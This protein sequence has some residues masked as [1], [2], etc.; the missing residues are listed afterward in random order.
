MTNPGIQEIPK[1]RADIFSCQEHNESPVKNNVVSIRASAEAMRLSEENEYK[2]KTIKPNAKLGSMDKSLH[3]RLSIARELFPRRPFPWD[4]LNDQLTLSLKQLG[5]AHGILPDP[6]PGTAM[7][8]LASAFGRKVIIR[9]KEDFTESLIFWFMDIKSMGGGKTGILEALAAPVKKLQLTSDERHEA[10]LEEWNRLSAE[11]QKTTE[12]PKRARGYWSSSFTMEG[13]RND[14]H[15]HPTGGYLFALDEMSS[16]FSGQ[17]AY[18][19]GRGSDREELC[20]LFNG[21]AGRILRAKEVFSIPPCAPSM[22]GGIQPGVFKR[23]LGGEKGLLLEDGTITRFLP[24]YNKTIHKD[25]T[26][27][28]VWS[29]ENQT[30]WDDLVKKA[31]LLAG[32]IDDSFIISFSQDAANVFWD[33]R[34]Q[35]NRI[36]KESIKIPLIDGFIQKAVT[37][38]VRFSGFLAILDS[39]CTEKPIPIQLFVSHINAGIKL[40]E[41]YLGQAVDIA[42]MFLENDE[43]IHQPDVVTDETLRLAKVL[44]FLRGETDKGLLAIGFITNEYNR[45]SSSKDQITSRKMGE[46]ISMAGLTKTP[47]LNDANGKRAVRCLVWDDKTDHYLKILSSTSERLQSPEVQEIIE[48]DAKKSMLEAAESHSGIEYDKDGRVILSRRGE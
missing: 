36:S 35:N 25:V 23:T 32:S 28:S 2:A 48:K 3:E 8:V 6:I 42:R 47:G 20:S 17:N 29:I 46:I 43:D 44:E 39:L 34:N 9:C 19:G 31:F 16:L 1:D 27:Y 14:L 7:A 13:L 37:Y 33:W 45:T 22:T 41:Y 12:R 26:A 5:D 38:T 11:D 40:I 15:R 4:V 21:K 10:A 30:A 18:R 24:V